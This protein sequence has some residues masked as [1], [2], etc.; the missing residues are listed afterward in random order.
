[1]KEKLKVE[2]EKLKVQN[3]KKLFRLTI[4]D[5]RLTFFCLQFAVY[6]LLLPSSVFAVDVIE[7]TLKE[8]VDI[9]VKENLSLMDEKQNLH[10]SDAEIKVKEGEF[11]PQF[12]LQL[13]ESYQKNASPY[14]YYS[15]VGE[16]RAFM[17]GAGI[18]GKI[19][20]GTK[21]ELKW[22]NERFK[23]N[24]T[25]LSLNPY[26]SS[27]LAL[28]VSQPLLKGMGKEIQ[29]SNLNVAKNNLDISRLRLN[30]KAMQIISDTTKAYWDLLSA[31]E[32]L[33]VTELSL[34]LARNLLDEAKARIEAG[35][36]APVEIY[37][38]EAEV[39]FRE[40]ALLRAKKFISDAEDR[41]RV[42]LN[43]KEW[44]KGILP[45]DKPPEP[46]EL[47]SMESALNT[48][49]S[50]RK[51]LRQASIDKKNKGI[52]RRFYENQKLPD[53]NIFGSTGLNGLN[54]S[55]SETLDKLSSGRYYSWQVG[56]SLNIPIENN[57]AKGNVLKARYDEQK[58]DINLKAIEQKIITE[59]REAWRSL[60]LASESIAATKKTRIASGKRLDAEEGRLRVG[61]ATMNDVLKFQEE[62]TRSLS[63]EKRAKIDYAKAIVELERVTGTLGQSL[64]SL[65]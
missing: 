14:I 59:V 22:T 50:N 24:S 33:E 61:M 10:I 21:Y 40:E 56:L 44:Q 54:S 32:E 17:S 2:T 18:E 3:L 63:S 58:A 34:K 62:Y 20:T 57:A 47:P 8:A 64:F 6:C 30:D 23:S 28:T 12:T 11:D 1:M 37:K 13:S 39:A 16:E 35:L 4:H 60:N 41:L 52:I 29:E 45:V 49:I 55:Y 15:T 9:A 36:L 25:F 53:L 7:L 42:T 31:R 65:Y 51:E 19:H 26:Y 38:A 27:G 46:S 48:A 5:S 43:L